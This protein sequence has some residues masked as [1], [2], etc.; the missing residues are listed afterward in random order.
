[1]SATAPFDYEAALWGEDDV[2]PHDRSIAAF[3]IH[4]ALQWLPSEGRVLEVGCGA[5]RMLRALREARPGLR[6]CGADVSRAAL[7]RAG[8]RS[9]DLELR[10]V[11]APHALL[12]AEDGEFDAV[13]LLD[14][15]EHVTDPG[16]FLAETRRVI[17]A[18]GVLHLH[19]PCE[20]DALSL[21]RWLPG[22]RGPRGVKQRLAGHVQRFRRRAVL[23]LLRD[24]GLTPLRVRHSLHVLGNLADV[25]AFVALAAR[26]RAG[27]AQPTTGD[28]LA[29]APDASGGASRMVRA[30]DAALFFEARLL[31]RIPAWGLHVSAR[32]GP[33]GQG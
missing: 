13:L 14:V 26:S 31:A 30:V 2:H 33:G 20:G 10:L 15:L 9:P 16:R 32:A 8:A 24:A 3:R 22:Q 5:G 23:A 25:G 6:L 27:R 19:V 21:W 7:A 12:P 4:E 28:L 1:M 18:G 11:K 29:G 17:R